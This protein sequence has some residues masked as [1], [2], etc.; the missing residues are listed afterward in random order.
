MNETISLILSR[1][2]GGDLVER[3][4]A[5]GGGVLMRKFW[6][7]IKI[8]EISCLTVSLIFSFYSVFCSV[9][10]IFLI[11]FLFKRGVGSYNLLV[12]TRLVEAENLKLSRRGVSPNSAPTG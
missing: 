5:N 6:E 1:T 11:F 2:T 4:G 10:L 3:L 9:S 8:N 12:S 7:N